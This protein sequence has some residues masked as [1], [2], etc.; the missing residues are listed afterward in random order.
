MKLMYQIDTHLRISFIFECILYHFDS[1]VNVML[2]Y[3]NQLQAIIDQFGSLKVSHLIILYLLNELGMNSTEVEALTSINSTVCR[4][5]K[6]R[7]AEVSINSQEVRKLADIFQ[8]LTETKVIDYK[9]DKG[10]VSDLTNVTIT[11]DIDL[12]RDLLEIMTVDQLVRKCRELGISPII[13]GKP[14]I[15][16]RILEATVLR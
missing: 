11:S 9:K 8:L 3:T 16:K 13:N 2:T 15:I 5:I 4:N 14:N 12:Q 7:N 10:T 6:R 1:F